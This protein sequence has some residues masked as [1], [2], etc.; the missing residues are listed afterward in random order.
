LEFDRAENPAMHRR[1]GDLEPHVS[2]GILSH[3]V[4]AL[5]GEFAVEPLPVRMAAPERAFWEKAMLLHEETF[6]PPG[7]INLAIGDQGFGTHDLGSIV[8]LAAHV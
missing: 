1:Q 8:L 2:P 7:S 5:P 6:L 3:Q 4:K